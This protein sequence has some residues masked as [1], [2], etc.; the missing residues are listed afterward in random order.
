[1]GR[2]PLA[3]LNGKNREQIQGLFPEAD[4]GTQF[5]GERKPGDS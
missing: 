5:Q 2:E 4:L 3:F 1:M